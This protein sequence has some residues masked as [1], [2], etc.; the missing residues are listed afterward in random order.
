MGPY[1]PRNGLPTIA[2]SGSGPLFIFYAGVCQELIDKQLL[3]PGVSNMAGISGG[4]IA[5]SVV[6][7]GTPPVALLNAYDAEQGLYC[8]STLDEGWP[9]SR[10]NDFQGAA[11]DLKAFVANCAMTKEWPLVRVANALRRMLPVDVS[12]VSAT[13]QV[14]ASQVN[15]ISYR[16]KVASS[17]GPF[18][19]REDLIAKVSASSMLPCILSGTSFIEVDGRP[20]V[21]GGFSAN[22]NQLC[23]NATSANP[24]LSASALHYGPHSYL[25]QSNKHGM[26][27]DSLPLAP[28]TSDNPPNPFNGFASYPKLDRRDW[29]LGTSK[30]GLTDWAGVATSFSGFVGPSPGTVVSINPGKRT[31]MPIT[32]CQWQSFASGKANRTI[33]RLIYEHGILEARAFVAEAYGF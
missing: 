12:A 25:P 24:C 15:P 20:Y 31:P 2:L 5:A 29:K 11:H 33:S 4:A 13:V 10:G 28:S 7:S 8:N 22:F 16:H 3:V 14:I 19:S 9:R 26:C 23:V 17:L 30:C 32:P 6:A 27:D 21:D 1:L 18:S